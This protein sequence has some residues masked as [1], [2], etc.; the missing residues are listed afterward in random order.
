MVVNNFL[1]KALCITNLDNNIRCGRIQKLVESRKIR[2]V[3]HTYNTAHTI[4]SRVWAAFQKSGIFTMRATGGRPSRTT[5]IT[6]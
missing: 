4:V 3:A 6:R 2:D 1:E 5:D